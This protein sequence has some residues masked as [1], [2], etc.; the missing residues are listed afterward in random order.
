M[1][2]KLQLTING[3]AVEAKLLFDRPLENNHEKWGKSYGFK[4]T[5]LNDTE[6][7]KKGDERILFLNE[8]SPATSQLLALGKDQ[9]FTIQK[10]QGRDDE[11]ANYIVTTP[12]GQEPKGQAPAP[13]KTSQTT[14]P[15][16]TGSA[17]ALV[18]VGFDPVAALAKATDGAYKA[19][20]QTVKAMA[21]EGASEEEVRALVDSPAWLATATD[22][23]YDYLLMKAR[24]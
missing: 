3:T 9:V 16:A 23:L 17:P 10:K 5:I 19:A 18:P 11:Y 13:A 4:L 1:T 15:A 22:K 21:A 2:E 12:E 6:D 20:E 24:S 14:A 7:A 8:K